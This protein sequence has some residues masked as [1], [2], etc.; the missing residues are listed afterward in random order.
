MV[1]YKYLENCE[2][3]EGLS[4]GNPLPGLRLT[5]DYNDLLDERGHAYSDEDLAKAVA[6]MK[7]EGA[8]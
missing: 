8:V 6:M 7:D 1:E 4:D 5:V 2:E 3:G